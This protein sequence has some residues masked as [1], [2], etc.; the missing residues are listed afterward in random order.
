MQKKSLLA[1]LLV[2]AMLLS[3]C[4]LITVDEEKDNAQPIV[5]VDGETIDKLTFSNYVYALVNSDST[6]QM[7]YTYGLTDYVNQYAAGEYV[8]EL[9]M[10]HEA[11]R[12][13]LDQLTDEDK[14]AVEEDA[15]TQYNSFLDAI[16]SSC[17]T[18]TGLDGDELRDAGA[19]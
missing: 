16:A 7:Y 14:Q 19:K 10:K 13:G 8:Q 6:M 17:L 18:D 2:L 9:V 1:L 3:G 5:D 15:L 4:A 12:Q 11:A